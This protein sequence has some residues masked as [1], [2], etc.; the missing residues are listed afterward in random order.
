MVEYQCAKRAP[1]RDMVEY[2]CAKRAPDRDMVE[3]QCAKHAPANGIAAHQ[4]RM[5]NASPGHYNPTGRRG[6]PVLS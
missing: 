3:Y 6:S 2:Q 5:K 4:W 1:G